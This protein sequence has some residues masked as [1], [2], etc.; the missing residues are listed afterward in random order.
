MAILLAIIGENK[1]KRKRFLRNL[2]YPYDSSVDVDYKTYYPTSKDND[3]DDDN[4]DNT[5]FPYIGDFSY[6]HVGSVD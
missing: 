4:D 3:N 6:D 2:D 5:P 1:E